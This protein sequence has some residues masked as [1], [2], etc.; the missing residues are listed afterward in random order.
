MSGWIDEVWVD[1][2][3]REVMFIPP[4][5]TASKTATMDHCLTH[6]NDRIR[7]KECRAAREN[8]VPGAMRQAAS[9]CKLWEPRLV[10]LSMLC[11]PLCINGCV[12]LLNGLA[13]SN[14]IG[15]WPRPCCASA[16]YYF[17]GNL[18]QVARQ[19]TD[20][21]DDEGSG[22]SPLWRKSKRPRN[23]ELDE[24]N[25]YKGSSVGKGGK[26]CSDSTETGCPEGLWSLLLWLYSEHTWMLAC[27]TYCREPALAPGL[28]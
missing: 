27:S 16:E 28:D 2:R 19:H 6:N 5:V 26:H 9:N 14:Q 1:D 18:G 22:I 12:Q 10:V 8:A 13:T 24:E 11:V 7:Q 25:A 23:I 15:V 17:L 3:P 20:C 4:W 21:K